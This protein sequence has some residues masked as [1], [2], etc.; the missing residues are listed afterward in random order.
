MGWRDHGQDKFG[1]HPE[2]GGWTFDRI[3]EERPE[4][5]KFVL[6][7]YGVT[8]PMKKFQEYCKERHEEDKHSTGKLDGPS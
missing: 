3:Y 5:I 2:I 7:W 1:E 4:Y 8:G 6:I